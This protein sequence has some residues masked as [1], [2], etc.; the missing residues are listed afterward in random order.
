MSSIKSLGYFF[1]IG[2]KMSAISMPTSDFNTDSFEI[3][4]FRGA[5]MIEVSRS[6]SDGVV[7]WSVEYSNDGTNWFDYDP[8]GDSSMQGL[9]IP[10]TIIDDDFLPVYVRLAFLSSGSPTGTIT[11]TITKVL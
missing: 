9:S 1:S 8:L 11:T 5:I 10:D 3:G 4:E 7:S 6:A 2:V